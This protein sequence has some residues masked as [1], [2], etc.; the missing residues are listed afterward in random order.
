MREHAGR[1]KVDGELEKVPRTC[2]LTGLYAQ[3]LP[4]SQDGVMSQAPMF[5]PTQNALYWL[6]ING[7]KLHKYVPSDASTKQWDLPEVAG[8]FAFTEDADLFLMGFA[9]GLSWWVPSTGQVE[10][11]CDFEADLNTRPNDG[12]CDH[13]G[14][15][16]IGTVCVYVCVCVCVCV[17]TRAKIQSQNADCVASKP[18][19]TQT[20]MHTHTHKHTHTHT[21][22]VCRGLQQ[23][24]PQRQAQHHRMLASEQGELQKLE[25][26]SLKPYTLS[27]GP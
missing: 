8:S 4:H 27:P 11:I 19:H 18:E 26:Y 17:Y 6:D 15:F 24:S 25:S 7:K 21:R 12:K 1:G 5:H 22:A 13:E 3:T 9:S 20:Q 16:V 23:Q 10:K 2:I 14:N